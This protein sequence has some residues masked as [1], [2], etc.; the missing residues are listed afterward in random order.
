MILT[1]I[2]QGTAGLDMMYRFLNAT[3][4]TGPS[5]TYKYSGF[6]EYLPITDPSNDPFAARYNIPTQN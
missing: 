5:D 6:E 3:Y 4:P 1:V 2:N